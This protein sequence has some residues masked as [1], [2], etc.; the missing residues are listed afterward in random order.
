MLKPRK[1]KIG[2][3]FK[4]AQGGIYD[5][6]G[7]LTTNVA[8]LGGNPM[9][10]ATG[11]SLSPVPK[12][13]V[14]QDNTNY[15]QQYALKGATAGASLMAVNP[16]VGLA[17]TAVGATAGAIGG[18]IKQ[19]KAQGQN[20]NMMREAATQQI[21]QNKAWNND[22]I[23]VAK[24]NDL[25]NAQLQKQQSIGA[26]TSFYGDYNLAKKGMK[27][28]KAE[29]GL[30]SNKNLGI[31]SVNTPY[32][33]PT[34]TGNT[35]PGNNKRSFNIGNAG[36]Y[37]NAAIGLVGGIMDYSQPT[38]GYIYKAKNG[39][40][41]AKGGSLDKMASDS[42]AINGPSHENGG[43]DMTEV[44][45]SP[46]EE[47]LEAEGGESMKDSDDATMIFS[48][49][50]KIPGSKLTFA[51]VHKSLATKRGSMEKKILKYAQRPSIDNKTAIKALGAKTA[52]IDQ[53]ENMLFQLQQQMNG[54]HSNENTARKGM[55]VTKAANGAAFNTGL[56]VLGGG[57]EYF[58]LE[59]RVRQNQ[60]ARANAVD[61]IAG[62][63]IPQQKRLDNITLGYARN[64]VAR[65]DINTQL[66][67]A[68]NIVGKSTS[69]NQVGAA[70][71]GLLGKG[72]EQNAA[73][74]QEQQNNMVQAGNETKLQN[75]S[76]NQINNQNAY[77]S[78]L[79]NLERNKDVINDKANLV[80]DYNKEHSE[81]VT[82][83]FRKEKYAD[84]SLA[85]QYAG[86]DTQ[87]QNYLKNMG[88]S[89]DHWTD[90][91]NRVLGSFKKGGSILKNRC[92][93]KLV[94]AGLGAKLQK[95]CGC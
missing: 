10:G 85:I 94:K 19:S 95:D 64:D 57:L 69:G 15:V 74:I 56:S 49:T 39:I 24:Q 63:Q 37:A 84:K 80:T 36:A 47:K 90:P 42:V 32:E 40:K 1:S 8:Q 23:N 38:T 61:Q 70:L 46:D 18:A 48:D 86:L 25:R 67:N 66:Q 59:N 60:K 82:D 51:D 50:L 92:G 62:L 33:A 9:Y 81:Y 27:V 73:L 41:L 16:V 22:S 34:P 12:I 4:A 54:N 68:T 17:A 93:G 71:T 14:N 13:K 77:Q 78:Q 7:N 45:D 28:V 83:N 76:I 26:K 88:L 5:Q 31:S 35:L 30:F 87:S 65:A 43:V 91:T 55:H 6:N 58:N 89:P 21:A 52:K 53:Q 72:L 29:D 79:M 3:I 11:N 75:L 20:R 44:V 2:K